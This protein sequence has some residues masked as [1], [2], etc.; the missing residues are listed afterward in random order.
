MRPRRIAVS[1]GAAIA[2]CRSAG[3][4]N[5]SGEQPA[6]HRQQLQ[7]G[8]RQRVVEHHGRLGRLPRE[9]AAR[10]DLRRRPEA[11]GVK[12]NKKLSIG[13]RETYI[14]ALQ[15]GSIDL[16]PEYTG[17]LAQY[18]N[19]DGQG[20]RRRR[21]LRRAQGVAA[22]H[23]HRAGQVGGRG[24]GLGRG[25]QGDRRRAEAELD[26]RPRGQVQGPGPRRPPGV[27]D[28]ADGRAGAEEGLRPGVQAVPPAR[29][30]RPPL[31]AG[32]EERPG[33]RGEHLHHRPEHPGQQLRRARGPEEPV[34]GPERRAAGSPRPRSTRRSRARSTR[35]RPSSTPRR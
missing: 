7:R 33:R 28:P 3:C 25:H 24:Q 5:D 2:L 21:R 9:R 26:R 1:I 31:G 22:G 15:D 6:G 19:K 27:E 14:P 20:H 12:V 10:R 18:F 17:V 13:S 35:S 8:W 30:R 34:R 11:K 29:R 23:P 32:A 4:G 16:I